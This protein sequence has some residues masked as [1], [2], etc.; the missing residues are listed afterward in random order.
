MVRRLVLDAVW[1]QRYAYLMACVQVAIFSRSSL[2]PVYI[3][4]LSVSMVC[5]VFLMFGTTAIAFAPRAIAQLPVSRRHMWLSQWWL[6]TVVSSAVAVL[7]GSIGM[8][9]VTD[10]VDLSLALMSFTYCM[11]YAGFFVWLRTTHLGRSGDQAVQPGGAR[12]RT[13][14][15]VTLPAMLVV[16]APPFLA[17]PYLPRAPAQMTAPW[18]VALLAMAGFAVR[19]Y[20]HHPLIEAR[21]S[22]RLAKRDP[23]V[24]APAVSATRRGLAG[25][26]TGLRLIAWD[27][28]RKQMTTFASVIAMV[29]VGWAVARRFL[30]VP[31]LREFLRL[32]DALPFTS[33]TSHVTEPITIG[34]LFFSTSF[35]DLWMTTKIRAWRALPVSSA[36]LGAIPVAMGLL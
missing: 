2:A 13:I 33:R 3:N 10:R 5:A 17:S 11:L 35:T 7:A 9:T 26:L 22:M 24:A 23:I 28:C 4:L 14:V 8:L 32:V 1:R 20:F 31:P 27:E 19:G 34:F 6:G 36:R 12:F 30:P 25:R 15:V 21:P 18:A 29:I 16:L